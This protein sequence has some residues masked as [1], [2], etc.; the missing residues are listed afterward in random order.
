M[1][2][3]DFLKRGSLAAAGAVTLPYILPQGRLFA[4]TGARKANHVVFCLFA[5][6]VRNLESVHMQDGNLMRCMFNGT[7][8]I[9]S[10]ILPG[11]DPVPASPLPLPLQNYGTLYK[12]FRY[13]QG[14]TGHYNG[15]ATAI[16]GVYTQTDLDVR[17]NPLNPTVFELYR[18]H[19]SPTQTALNSWWVSNTLGPYVALNYSNAE[20]YG[21]AYGGN[22]I[23]PQTFIEAGY[24]ALANPKTFSAS[25]ESIIAE[26]RNFVDQNFNT[27]YI[28]GA[29]GV[30]NDHA[31]KIALQSFIAD[32]FN[33]AA[34]GLFINPWQL[35]NVNLMNGD[36]YNIF[37]AEEILKQFKPE[38]LVV[39]MQGVDICHSNFT[40]YA[41]N[42]RKADYAVAHL[43]QTIQNTPGLAN[44]T[45]MIIAPEHGRNLNPNSL[46]DAYGRKALD[47]TSDNTSREIFCMVV[48]PPSVIKQGQT[49]TQTTGQSIDI[50]PTIAGILGFD[51]QIPG[52]T[53]TGSF[54][55]QAF[56]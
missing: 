46:V 28:N 43:W 8:N 19:N 10:D 24:N 22:F 29:A 12:E 52:G 14:P 54:L 37:F 7:Q 34:N 11:L 48:G 4:A 15:H 49:I 25:E 38:L 30:T 18:K 36:M 55:H 47:H 42:L 17:A 53:L 26:I 16:T 2:R 32:T 23:S 50:I 27:Q 45:I 13:A 21:A 33:K 20:G 39:N 9:S 41:N 44:D 35:P 5:G 6:G 56:V 40:Q 51:T 31:D 1:Q 3:R